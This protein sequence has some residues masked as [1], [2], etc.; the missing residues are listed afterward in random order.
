MHLKADLAMSDS[1]L[2]KT[3][4]EYLV[5]LSVSGRNVLMQFLRALRLWRVAIAQ[6]VDA[7]GGGVRRDLLAQ[8]S[9]TK[10]NR[11]IFLATP[12]RVSTR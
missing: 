4:R 11:L 5:A 7:V 12:N 10:C 2:S 6:S 1:Y 3:S 9:V 8:K